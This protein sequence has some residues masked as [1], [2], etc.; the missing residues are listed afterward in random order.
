[1]QK[2]VDIAENETPGCSYGRIELSRLDTLKDKVQ[3]LEQECF[4]E[5]IQMV[6]DGK[7]SLD[8]NQ[9]RK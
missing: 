1:M 8:S 4:L 7:L 6:I 5:A 9:A 2:K 3:K